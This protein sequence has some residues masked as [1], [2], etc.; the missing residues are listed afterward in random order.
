M[1]AAT[2]RWM[3]VISVAIAAIILLAQAFWLKKIYELE[4]KNF[5]SDVVK[6]IRGLMEDIDIA[7]NPGVQLQQLVEHPTPNNFRIKLNRVPD[8]DSLAY[9]LANELQDFGIISSC[10]ASV[11]DHNKNEFVYTKYLLHP[12]NSNPKESRYTLP[13]DALPYTYAYL[14]FPNREQFILRQLNYWILGTI[15]L[16]LTL[17]AMAGS[18]FHLYRQKTLN[19]LQRDFVNNFTHEFKTPLAVMKLAAEVITNPDITTKPQKLER[20]GKIIK[21]QTE[22]LQNQVERLLHS[23][24]TDQYELPLQLEKTNLNQLVEQAVEQ[25]DPLINQRAVKLDLHLADDLPDILAD[26]SHIEM[27]I[28]NLVENAIKYSKD[29]HVIITTESTNTNAV[30]S[31][32]DNGIGIEKQYLPFLYKKFYRIP[33]GDVHDVKGFGLGLNFVK[34]VVDAHRGKI[35][36]Q[37]IPGIGTIFSIT[38]PLQP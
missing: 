27:V 18:L 31:V 36:I 28:V 24:T 3:V 29:P 13:E 21:E 8:G 10:I 26:S 14:T 22:H 33:T 11:Y 19:E 30:L 12:A 34:K 17:L 15:I 9:Y 25:L 7:E 4:Q 35:N 38:L 23:A 16:L 6:C 1:R 20:Y 32:K 2:L 5:N 37:S